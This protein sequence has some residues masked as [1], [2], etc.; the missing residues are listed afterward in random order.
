MMIKLP[1]N[2][3]QEVIKDRRNDTVRQYTYMQLAGYLNISYSHAK[4]IIKDTTIR[5]GVKL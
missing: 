1:I 5:I 4:T 3:Y 2:V